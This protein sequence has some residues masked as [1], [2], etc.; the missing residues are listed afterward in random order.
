ML[1]EMERRAKKERIEAEMARIKAEKERLE[2]E[3][4]KR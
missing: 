3:E 1:V 2:A 4:A